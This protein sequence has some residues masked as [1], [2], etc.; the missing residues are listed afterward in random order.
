V[1]WLV[2]NAGFLSGN[3]FGNDETLN[4][5]VL[6]RTNPVCWMV[7]AVVV[8]AGVCYAED[9][10]IGERT[11]RVAEGYEVELAVDPLQWL[12]MN[13]GDSTSPTQAG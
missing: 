13:E 7:L 4:G 2:P 9:V 3:R 12:V 8:P 10:V 11:L 6:M 5:R 1:P